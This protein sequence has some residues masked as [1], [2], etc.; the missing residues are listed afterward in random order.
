MIPHKAITL[1]SNGT[2]T[3]CYTHTD[4]WLN[5]VAHDLPQAVNT[6]LAILA[7][8]FQEA[9]ATAA[10]AQLAPTSG[11]EWEVEVTLTDEGEVGVSRVW[12]RGTE[13]FKASW[14]SFLLS[15]GSVIFAL[16]MHGIL[17]LPI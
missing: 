11:N 15:V 4:F 7:E 12:W 6:T 1:K 9:A 3:T 2:S 5:D 16:G 13:T 10:V 17:P 8:R 14:E